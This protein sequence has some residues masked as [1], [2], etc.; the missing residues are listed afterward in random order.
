MDYPIC[1]RSH[2]SFINCYINTQVN[3]LVSNIEFL[4]KVQGRSIN[5]FCFHPMLVG[6][7]IHSY[8]FYN[9]ITYILFPSPF[10][11]KLPKCDCFCFGLQIVLFNK[12]FIQSGY[13]FSAFQITW[14]FLEEN[15]TQLLSTENSCLKFHK[16][17]YLMFSI[18]HVF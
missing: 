12:H 17:R 9:S 15:M 14:V 3:L 2:A 5:L 10:S 16:V 11:L 7:F 8:V 6:N 4:T 1:F 18:F 13:C